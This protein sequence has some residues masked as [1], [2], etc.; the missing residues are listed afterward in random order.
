MAVPLRVLIDT[1]SYN[2]VLDF[3][4][5]RE[6]LTRALENK[7]VFC[8]FSIVRKELRAI[9]K[10]NEKDKRFRNHVLS[11]YDQLVRGHHYL[12]EPKIEYLANLYLANYSG[13]IS[14]AKLKNDFLIVACATVHR[15]DVIVT[16]D[17]HSLLSSLARKT[18][19]TVNEANRLRE[20]RFYTVQE[21]ES[22][23][24]PV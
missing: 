8:G 2:V 19:Q 4:L 7:A 5:E 18:Y 23:S 3:D 14:K 13:G 11:Y 10:T 1:S 21:F 12:L 20:P 24:R 17:R 16:E 22:I 9:P 6:W 15:L